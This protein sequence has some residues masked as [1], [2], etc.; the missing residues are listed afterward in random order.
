MQL[1]VPFV[2]AVAVLVRLAMAGTAFAQ[3]AATPAPAL[4]ALTGWVADPKTGCKIW[5]AAP[6][7]AEKI[8]WSG[9][10]EDGMADGD[11]TLQFY[12]GN[13]PA[14]RYEG[15]MRNGRSDGHGVNVEPD[16][17]RYEGGWRN[18]A[19]NGQGVYTK[20]GVRYEGMWFNGC[21]KQGE[22]ELTVGV[23]NDSCG[24]K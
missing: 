6:D 9:K 14:A 12:I 1:Y 21:L 19:A 13:D 22:A 2:A 3:A 11:G 7:P 16:G 24:F 17:T 4:D 23:S 15:E 5:D 10:C 20:A 8:T 18:N